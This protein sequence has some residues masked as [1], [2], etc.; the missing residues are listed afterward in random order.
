VRKLL[1]A[2][3]TALALGANPGAAQDMAA[4]AGLRDGDMKKL[5]LHSTPVPL[6]EAGLH[7][8]DDSPVSLSE[9]QGQWVVVNFWATWCA[10]C[11]HEMP[12]LDR[13]QAALPGLVVVP[14]ATGRNPPEGIARF[15]EESGIVHLESWRDPKGA[16]AKQI[17]VLGLPVTLVLNPEGEEVARLIGDADWDSAHAVAVLQALMTGG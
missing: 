17:G 6:P 1:V 4:V 13:L 2:V 9:L 8:L 12:A 11:R 16:L 15:W 5:A 3:Y 14:I 10:P 7:R